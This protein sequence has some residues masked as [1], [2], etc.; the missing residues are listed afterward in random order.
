MT[1]PLGVAL[2]TIN[3]QLNQL[4]E[5]TFPDRCEISRPTFTRTEYGTTAP[6]YLTVA[7]LIGCVWAP[8]GKD[9]KEYIRAL[10]ITGVAVYMITLPAATDVKPKD[11]IVVSARGDEPER[12]FEVKGPP[13]RNAGLP[14]SVLC[15]LEE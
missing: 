13:L 12:T 2:N 9:A 1:S 10:K 4:I 8:A 11:R 6:S 14:I 3:A 15:T 5:T 7:S